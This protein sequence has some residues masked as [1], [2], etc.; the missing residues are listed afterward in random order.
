LAGA[1]SSSSEELLEDSFLAAAF[2]AGA[3]LAAGFSLS[4]ESLSEEESFLA[5]LAFFPE[6]AEFFL[7]GLAFSDSLDEL[8]S[9]LDSFLAGAFLAGAAFFGA[10]FSLSEELSSDEEDDCFLAGFLAG[11]A[12]AFLAMTLG[13][14]EEDESSS[15]ELSCTFCFFCGTFWFS[16]V[17]L[18]L[19]FCELAALTLEAALGLFCTGLA[20]EDELLSLLLS[21]SLS[22]EEDSC[23]FLAAVFLVASFWALFFLSS[24]LC[25]LE[26]G[27]DELADWAIFL[28][29]F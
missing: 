23:F 27:S 16:V 9:E 14:S 8:S 7:T 12:G 1:S 13:S 15:D 22:E 29:G 28:V 17:F 25:F 20:W 2:F 19:F 5:F 26:G 24:M 4:E 11:A 3:F 21:S 6:A 10:G 18:A